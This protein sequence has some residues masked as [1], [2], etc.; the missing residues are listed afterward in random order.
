M[1]V[2]FKSG[3]RLGVAKLAFAKLDIP[4]ARHKKYP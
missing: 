4:D 1:L 2:W 3:L